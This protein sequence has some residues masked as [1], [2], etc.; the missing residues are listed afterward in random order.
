MARFDSVVESCAISQGQESIA[1]RRGWGVDCGGDTSRAIGSIASG[2]HGSTDQLGPFLAEHISLVLIVALA[3]L[4]V[5]FCIQL[6]RVLLER[7]RG[8]TAV[9]KLVLLHLFMDALVAAVSILILV[10]LSYLFHWAKA[11]IATNLS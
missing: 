10:G 4:F 11:I 2:G 5:D 1:E 7:P 9:V 8:H 6:V 3:A